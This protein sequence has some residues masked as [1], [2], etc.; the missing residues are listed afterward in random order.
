[1]KMKE[2]NKQNIFS[3]WENK[4]RTVSDGRRRGSC[5]NAGCIATK[6]AV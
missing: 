4:S 5:A 6:Q 1:M 2:E 3:G